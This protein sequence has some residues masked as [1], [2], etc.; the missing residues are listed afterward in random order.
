MEDMDYLCSSML[1]PTF[2]LLHGHKTSLGGGI[3]GTHFS[4]LSAF[5]LIREALGRL[6]SAFVDSHLPP[7]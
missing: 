2:H 4:D 3:Y 6:F 1:A 5:S 7:A